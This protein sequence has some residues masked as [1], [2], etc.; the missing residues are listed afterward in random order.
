MRL[1]RVNPTRH[2]ALIGCEVGGDIEA[3]PMEADAASDTYTDGSD[4][5]IGLL[6]AYPNADM[7]WMEL[8]L[9]DSF[10]S[11][12]RQ[13]PRLKTSDKPAQVASVASEGEDHIN[14][15]LSRP[16]IG[17]L[18][19]S[20]GGIDRVASGLQEFLGA[21]PRTRRV[22]RRMLQKPDELWAFSLAHFLVVVL[23]GR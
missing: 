6:L 15:P 12:S 5:E 14:D 23:H 9:L 22:K 8:R 7:V 10:V 1:E 17:I 19:A 4:F 20:P 16:V 11:K 2:D 21:R 13:H 18:P 3:D